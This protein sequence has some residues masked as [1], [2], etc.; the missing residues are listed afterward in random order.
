MEYEIL[1]VLALLAALLLTHTIE[2]CG[3]ERRVEE[4]E[5]EESEP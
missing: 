5:D 2:W 4:P 1:I 3:P